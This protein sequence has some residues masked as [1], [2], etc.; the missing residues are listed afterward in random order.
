M[1][2]LK[3]NICGVFLLINLFAAGQQSQ[4]SD[5]DNLAGKLVK[6]LRSEIQ[7]NIFIHTDKSIYRVGE[8]IWFNAYLINKIS[9][10][11]SHESKIVFV[12]LVNDND[13]V[14]SQ[15]V[16][17]VRSLRL[18]GNI[19]LPVSLHDGNYWLR[20]YTNA[21]LRADSSNIC[22]YPI[23]IV[24]QQNS[25]Q[26]QLPVKTVVNNADDPNN[27][28]PK[29]EVYP[30]G[31]SLIAGANS[32]VA[33][34]VTDRDNNLL[35]VSGYLKD[36]RDSTTLRFKTSL[37]G[38]GKFVLFPWKTRKYTAYI[39]TKD[40]RE[41]SYPLPTVDNNAASISIVSENENSLKARVS[42]GDSLY[43]RKT[44]TYILGIS[45]DSLCFAGVGERMY[46]TDIPKK[47]FPQGQAT[48]LLFDEHERL[49]S[50]RSIYIDNPSTIV[51]VKD[52]K[53]NYLAR[54]GAMLNVSLT[55]AAGHPALSLFS[56][57]VTDDSTVKY[58]YD[59]DIETIMKKPYSTEEKDLIMLVQKNKYRKWNLSDSTL[60]DKYVDIDQNFFNTRGTVRN[61]NNQV[62]GNAV[63]T[64]FSTQARVFRVDTTDKNGHFDFRLSGFADS[65]Q[66]MLQVSDLKGKSL[67]AKITLD[68]TRLPRFSTPFYLKK[69]LPAPASL[70]IAQKRNQQQDFL[71]PG[72]GKEL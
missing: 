58:F 54:D 24:N 34:R 5:L 27:N 20:G 16:L 6:S 42:L 23:Y 62:L 32:L 39:K 15:L 55:D 46:E 72:R 29:F 57:S 67:D 3:K 48:L 28:A 17:D 49:L 31:G 44:V 43:D 2:N 9:H 56:V 11:I 59:D 71:L 52:D 14:I 45:R 19:P 69:Y 41:Y 38:L 64:L 7:E 21:M 61:Q 50:E 10:K 53:E 4:F 25:S 13:S 65:V 35:D 51:D 12:D 26:D 60:N 22:V 40:G 47:N 68:S 63:V 33:F 8:N 30:E 36:N 70:E 1:T 66:L 37:P 18:D